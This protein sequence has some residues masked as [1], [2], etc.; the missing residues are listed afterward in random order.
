MDS[1]DE[2]KFKEVDGASDKLIVLDT[3]T[4]KKADASSVAWRETAN[5]SR[6]QTAKKILWTSGDGNKIDPIVVVRGDSGDGDSGYQGIH[7]IVVNH[8]RFTPI[9]DKYNNDIEN[10]YKYWRINTPNTQQEAVAYTDDY[11]KFPSFINYVDGNVNASSSN[12]EYVTRT[13]WVKSNLVD[14][15]TS[16]YKLYQYNK[17]QFKKLYSKDF[18]S[19]LGD[20]A[21]TINR[22]IYSIVGS[23]ELSSNETLDDSW[24]TYINNLIS[25]QDIQPKRITP[26]KA[27]PL[28]NK[29]WFKR[30]KGVL[31]WRKIRNIY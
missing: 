23:S 9:N 5:I 11:N 25:Y 13:S 27:I 12:N 20:F 29:R 19:Y 14:R 10:D 31:K 30:Y 6:V 3:T 21:T 1:M 7:F 18:D 2:T 24:E 22:Y 4:V 17:D 15:G 8:I 16:D 28:L 26:T